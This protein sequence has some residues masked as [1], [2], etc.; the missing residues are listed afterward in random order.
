MSQIEEKEEKSLHFIEQIILDDLAIGKNNGRLQT[1]FPPE[2]NGYLHI[3]HAKAIVVNFG[4]AAQYGGV[5]NLRF[6]D[7]NPVTEETLFVDRIREDVSWLGYQWGQEC[8]ASDYFDTLYAFAHDLIDKGLAYVDDSSSAQIAEMKGNPATPGKNSPFRD[9]TIAENKALFTAMKDGSFKD[10]EKV[11]RAKIDMSSPNMHFRDPII[12]RIKHAHHHR[13]ADKWCIYPMYDFA[14]GQ[15]DAIENITHSLC[16]LEFRHHRDLYDWF[17]QQL[18]IFPSRQIEFARMNVAYMITSKR[19]LLRLIQENLVSGWDDPRM[20]TISGMRRRGYPAKAIVAFCDRAGV[21]KRDNLISIEL[22]EFSVREVLNKTALRAMAVLDPVKVTLSNFPENQVDWLPMENNPEDM[23]GGTRLVPF[24]NQLYIE[25]DDFS[26]NPPPKYFRLAPGQLV[27]LKGAYIIK[28]DEVIKNKETGEI[29]EI[30]C[31][32]FPE[33]KSG[34]DTSGLKVKGTL[35]WVEA[36]HAVTAEIRDYERLFTVPEPTADEDIDFLS[37]VNKDSLK[38]NVSA[39]VEASLLDAAAGQTYQF[40]R[41]GY[42]CKDKDSR[43]D[44]PVFNRTVGLK[45]SF[46]TK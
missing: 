31:T 10:G 14:H 1:R 16:S 26:E 37:F 32:Y 17:I 28:C 6:D 42:Y 30:L 21:A 41:Q 12:Y 29:I 13:T 23:E 3:G 46:V 36:S 43:S 33:S 27:R 45:D 19:K 25:R 38:I 44:L 2:P 8:Y 35:H 4:L 18:G 5:C 22:L 20:S 9:R 7:T 11:L 34:Q 24:S 40:L 15:S 39:K